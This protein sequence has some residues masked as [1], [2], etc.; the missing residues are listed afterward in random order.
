MYMNSLK[1][2]LDIFRISLCP[3]FKTSLL[4]MDVDLSCSFS[5]CTVLQPQDENLA[6]KCSKIGP[7]TKYKTHFRLCQGYQIAL[8]APEL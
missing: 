4:N 2:K 3:D 5:L 8:E 7:I 1:V 6:T